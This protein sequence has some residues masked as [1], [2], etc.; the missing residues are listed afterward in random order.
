VNDMKTGQR[1]LWL[2]AGVMI[3]L[4]VSWF[5][6]QEPLHAG[7]SDRDDKFAMLTVPVKDVQLAG[8]RDHL[9]GVFVL[10]FL[11]GKLRGAVLT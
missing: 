9:E 10:D 4:A 8:V 11:T 3:G 2:M 6:P 7:S 5:W 1:Y